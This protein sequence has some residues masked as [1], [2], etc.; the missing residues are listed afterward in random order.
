[1]EIRKYNIRDI[2][3]VLPHRYPFLL[4]DTI[5]VIE[6][7]AKGVGHKNVTMNEPFFQGHFPDNPIMPG[8]LQI[9]AMAQAAGFVIANKGGNLEQGRVLFMS[10]D[11]AK[12]RKQVIPGDC[13]DIHVEK[14]KE[15]RNIYVCAGKIFVGETLVAEAEMTA[16][17]G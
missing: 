3:K 17:V 5:E 4:L 16:M 7:G 6:D 10:V 13:L 11:K 12:F 2:I 9:E 1:M 15:R 8:V 14:I